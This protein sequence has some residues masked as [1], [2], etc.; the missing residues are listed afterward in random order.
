MLRLVRLAPFALVTGALILGACGGAGDEDLTAPPP[1]DTDADT[2]A[3]AKVEGGVTPTADGGS[4]P[5][6]ATDGGG[7]SDAALGTEMSGEATYYDPTGTSAC[8]VKGTATS[9]YAAMNAA[10][11]KKADCG[12][13]VSVTG[14]KGTTVVSVVD[15]C[16]GCK[17][18]DLDLGTSAFAKIANLSA[19]RVKIKWHFV[20]C[21]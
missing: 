17:A 3:S 5:P 2:S 14:P 15:K 9:P 20:A 19:G 4:A 6:T 18:G 8:G 16:P 7:G 13:C 21:P 11:Y 12:K 10:Q 1:D